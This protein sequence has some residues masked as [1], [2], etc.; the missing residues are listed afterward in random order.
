MHEIKIRITDVF[1]MLIYACI[2]LICTWN[3]W[4][5]WSCMMKAPGL[6]FTMAIITY[7]YGI[8]AATRDATYLIVKIAR[9][10]MKNEN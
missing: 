8:Y 2:I 5:A 1:K 10:T 4:I 9:R 6:Y 3:E 7:A